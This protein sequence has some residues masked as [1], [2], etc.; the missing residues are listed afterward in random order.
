MR[1]S[2]TPGLAC[3]DLG[4]LPVGPVLCGPWRKFSPCSL[5]NMKKNFPWKRGLLSCWV[6]TSLCLWGHLHLYFHWQRGKV[7]TR[8]CV[9][10][11]KLPS[12]LA[13][14][15]F[16]WPALWKSPDPGPDL[17]V[18]LLR[19]YSLLPFPSP[20]PREHTFI[21]TL[22]YWSLPCASTVTWVFSVGNSGGKREPIPDWKTNWMRPGE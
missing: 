10:L 6:F 3:A 15:G 2:V 11:E 17:N 21:L 18:F 20:I 7:G 9:I 19:T 5:L 8:S 13:S 14:W 16:S 12:G 1:F 22:W 4:C